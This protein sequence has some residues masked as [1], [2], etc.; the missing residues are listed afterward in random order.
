M[1]WA[2]ERAKEIVRPLKGISPKEYDEL[3]DRVAAE[4]QR[5]ADECAETVDCRVGPAK[6]IR[7]KFPKEAE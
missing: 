6:D 3:W 2:K 1:N 5:V 4:L 7:A